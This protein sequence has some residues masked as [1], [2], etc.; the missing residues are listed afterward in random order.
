MLIRLEGAVQERELLPF[1]YPPLKDLRQL[2]Y[3]SVCLG[4]YIP[5]DVKKQYEIIKS[6]LGWNGDEVENIPS[7]Y[8]YEKI[9]CYLQGVRDYIK[10]IKRGYART[11]HLVSIDIRNHRLTRNE[12]LE[13]I[14][15]YEGKRPPSL[16]IFLKF[17]GIDEEAFMKIAVNH[18]VSPWK[19]ERALNSFG[20]EVKDFMKWCRAGEMPEDE[21]NALMERWNLRIK[22]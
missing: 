10:Y 21:I 4:S 12:A 11:T 5:W 20:P 16:D 9:E 18:T 22:K 19:Y 3:R 2:N 13:L 6:E 7:G 15:K 8:E 17:I 1:K 14:K